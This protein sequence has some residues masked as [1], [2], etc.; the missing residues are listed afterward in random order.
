MPTFDFHC[1]KCNYSF[2]VYN[3]SCAD[4][5]KCKKCGGKTK[6]MPS[7]GAGLIFKGSGWYCKDYPRGGGRQK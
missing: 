5:I 4:E 3:V 6:R 2:E 7:C 1:E